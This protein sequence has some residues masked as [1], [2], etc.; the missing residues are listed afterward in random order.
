MD[1]TAQLTSIIKRLN[2]GEDPGQ[3]K[4]EAKELLATIGADDLAIAEQNLMDEG[5]S[6]ED[7]QGLCPIHLEVLGEQL[8]QLRAGLPKGHVVSTLIQEHDAILGFLD[9][10]QQTNETIQGLSE[11]PGLTLE[12][13]KLTHIAEHLVETER[14]HQREED[15]LFPELEKRGMQGPP[16][17]MREEH[18]QLRPRKRQLKDLAASAGVHDFDDFKRRL[19][20]LTGFIVPTLRE[21]I[22]KENNILYP[23]ALQVIEDDQVWQRLKSDCDVI[24]YCCFTPEA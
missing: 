14:H 16:M 18:R 5:L 22:Y 1:K 23:A 17:V 8:Q 7:V 4:A 6:V 13:Q 10:L 12:F 11:Y 3:V 19:N 21:H 9:L 24:G 20:A 15:V 2:A